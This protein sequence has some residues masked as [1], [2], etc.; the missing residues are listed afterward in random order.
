MIK[1]TKFWF[2]KVNG[3]T[4]AR[5]IG[6]LG[7]DGFWYMLIGVPTAAGEFLFMKNRA[8]EWVTPTERLNRII[9]HRFDWQ[10]KPF[11]SNDLIWFRIKFNK[12]DDSPVF[13]NYY[14]TAYPEE[15]TVVEKLEKRWDAF[16]EWIKHVAVDSRNCLEIDAPVVDTIKKTGENIL[17]AIQN[18]FSNLNNLNKFTG[19]AI[20]NV[21]AH[22]D[23]EFNE[24]EVK[25][26][27]EM[28]EFL[29]K[30]IDERKQRVIDDGKDNSIPA[31]DKAEL[32]SK[33]EPAEPVKESK[34]DKTLDKNIDVTDEIE[35]VI[36]EIEKVIENDSNTVTF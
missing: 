30:S 26:S 2:T 13:V 24:N 11:E 35:D 8:G 36:D 17:R 28:I 27:R 18:Q 1:P 4:K 9:D 19:Y 12:L 5:V 21:A 32:E 33:E 10:F 25:E 14:T 23:K 20:H 16:Q 6:D 31:A 3:A 22:N 15:K 7:K 34:E 29:Y